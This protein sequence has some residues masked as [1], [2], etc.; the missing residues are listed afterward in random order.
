[1]SA[2]LEALREGERPLRFTLAEG[3]P[4]V[5]GRGEEADLRVA[6][7]P[8]L[9]RKHF[10][11]K[12]EGGRLRVD[13]LSGAAN[14]VYLQGE[15]KDGFVLSPGEQFV[16]GSTRFAFR[17]DGVRAEP[18]PQAQK[19]L[20]ASEVYKD[21][22]G[23][24]RLRLLDLLELP[25]LLRVKSEPEFFL[26]V[27]TMLRLA[28][29]A[30]WVAV[31]NQEGRILALDV[32][33]E[34]A[35]RP[36]WSG[37]LVR[38]ALAEAPRPTLYTWTPGGA[39][40]TVQ[41]GVDWAIAAAVR[42]PGEP[43][44][45][46][47]AAGASQGESAATLE[48][49]ARLVGLVADLVGRTLSVRRLEAREGRFAQFFSKPVIEKMLESA[50]EPS[51][52]EPHVAES[53]VMFCDIRG[54]SKRLEEPAGLLLEHIGD[55]R[56]AM[57]AIS[58][59]IFRENGVVLRYTGDGIL[60]CWNVPLPDR[61][62]V[63]SAVRAALAVTRRLAEV[64]PQWSCGIGLHTGEVVAG[65]LG[66][67][68]LF[69]YTVLGAVVNQASRIEGITKFVEAPVLASREVASRVSPAAAAPLRLGRFQPAGMGVALDLFELTPPPGDMDRAYAI[70]QGLA[71]LE[72]GD[73]EKAYEALNE[74]PAK[75][76]PARF[77]KS[78]AEQYRRRP[79]KDWKGV[80]ELS[81]K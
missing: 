69:S 30:R 35:E 5:V 68:Q 1:M 25:E 22:P 15:A 55:L 7:D 16:V 18:P 3:T 21:A 27:S 17:V 79:P 81:E 28:A 61:H 36:E 80:I 67:E 24:D 51:S 49:S 38:K 2:F 76:L 70:G 56:R 31:A 19:T 37:T 57:T 65:A 48:E 11:V 50:G 20:E 26:H 53:T 71:A 14:P 9:S 39:E 75:D 64:A 40:A 4:S 63:D 52:L 74:R 34:V 44:I 10:V 46:F 13:R 78:L 42:V 58:E 32:A 77:L 29:R 60:A 72:A 41:E 12:L 66:S 54:F 6:A 8:S 47:Y 33:E 59:E 73:W 45:V 62:H 23:S 43:A